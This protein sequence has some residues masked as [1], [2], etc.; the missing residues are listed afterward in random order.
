M[1]RCGII[2]A[3]DASRAGLAYYLRLSRE[4][5]RP[6]T[7]SVARLAA[8]L[9]VNR[10]T[11]EDVLQVWSA[12]RRGGFNGQRCRPWELAAGQ[13]VTPTENPPPTP[14]ENPPPHKRY[15]RE[16][17]VDSAGATRETTPDAYAPAPAP[18][19]PDR[20]TDARR[21][22]QAAR[23]ADEL[24]HD[25]SSKCPRLSYDGCQ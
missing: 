16:G 12:V 19:P 10:R 20:Q 3:A 21:A 9:G 25:Q 11:C 2:S 15:K 6:C 22:A 14:T 23:A 5:G 18:P 13:P 8:V 4:R 1:V 17:A 24:G 7:V